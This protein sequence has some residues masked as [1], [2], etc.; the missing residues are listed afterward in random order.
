M[1]EAWKLTNT[2]AVDKQIT[3]L[4]NVPYSQANRT[5]H[6]ILKSHKLL[7]VR[8]YR[9]DSQSMPDTKSVTDIFAHALNFI[10]IKKMQWKWQYTS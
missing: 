10:E 7:P 5:V 6:F 1:A 4:N 2:N 9:K 8:P 3:Y